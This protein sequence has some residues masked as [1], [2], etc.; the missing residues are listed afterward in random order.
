MELLGFVENPYPVLAG[1]RALIAP[2]FQGAGVKFKVLE[3]LACGTTVVGTEIA[4]EGIAA[5]PGEELIRCTTGQDFITEI[6][7]QAAAS[8]TAEEKDRLCIGRPFPYIPATA[9]LKCWHRTI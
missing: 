1:A 4:L 8:R 7:K 9:S 3:A 2:L 5:D 6:N